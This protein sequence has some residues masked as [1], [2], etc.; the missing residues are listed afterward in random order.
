MIDTHKC[1]YESYLSDPSV[2]ILEQSSSWGMSHVR[3]SHVS[4]TNESCLA[5][6][7]V[8]SHVWMSHVSR[9]NASCLI[10]FV[11]VTWLICMCDMTHPYLWHDSSN[12]LR[13]REELYKIF[14]EFDLNI[15]YFICVTWLLHMCDMTHSYV[16]HD[17]FIYVTWLIHMCDMTHS[18]P[19]GCVRSCMYEIFLE[20]DLNIDYFICVTWL[21]HM[22]GMT[23]SCMW[24]DSFICVTRLIQLLQTSRG[25]IW[26]ISG[27]W[28]QRGLRHVPQ[29]PVRAL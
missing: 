1:V 5:Y 26:D 17:S 9:M 27:V 2:G 15:D 22:C 29:A 7:W 24:H 23:H 11:R 10:S 21:I 12:F 4:R 19:S 18:T 8:M 6:E 14:L 3:M 28:S 20:F 25:V 13:L 16:W